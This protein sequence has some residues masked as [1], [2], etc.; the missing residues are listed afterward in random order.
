VDKSLGDK[1]IQPTV[2][3]GVLP[4]HFDVPTHVV[5]LSTFIATARNT[6]TVIETFNQSLLQGQLEYEIFVLPAEQG[7]FKSQLAI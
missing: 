4:I 2:P 3:V 5:S 1:P 6:K 7:S